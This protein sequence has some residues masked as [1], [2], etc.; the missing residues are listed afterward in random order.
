V[1]PGPEVAIQL[2]RDAPWS[3]RQEH[4]SNIR[5]NPAE[6]TANHETAR[7]HRPARQRYD[8]GSCG[9][10]WSSC[11]TGSSAMI[12]KQ[13]VVIVGAGTRRPAD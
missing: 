5:V 8:Q 11:E 9:N 4:F 6:K 10:C 2:L 13:S 3:L 7:Q 12:G 1:G